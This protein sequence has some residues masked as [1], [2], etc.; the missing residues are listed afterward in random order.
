VLNVNRI[1]EI[2]ATP[3]DY[4]SQAATLIYLRETTDEVRAKMQET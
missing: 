1:F 4:N 2:K 3:I